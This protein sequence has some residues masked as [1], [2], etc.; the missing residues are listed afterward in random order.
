MI[1]FLERPSPTGSANLSINRSDRAP[2]FTLHDVRLMRLL[3]PHLQR[4]LALHRRFHHINARRSA[5]VS[6]IDRLSYGVILVDARLRPV[7]VNAAANQILSE[8]DG[9]ILDRGALRGS[10]PSETAELRRLVSAAAAVT[11]GVSSSMRDSAMTTGRRSP[12]EPLHVL[13]TPVSTDNQY[14]GA[15]GLA[16]AAVFITDPARIASPDERTLQVLY[17]FTPAEARVAAVLARGLTVPQIAQSLDLTIGTARW[18]VKQLR[19]K[20]GAS[21]HAKLIRQLLG[22]PGSIR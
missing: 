9:L 16:V 17:G 22:G 19:A 15:E 14:A 20:T 18:Y 6:V 5:A 12:R 10:Q 11:T 21:T 1:S 13:V 2:E 7:V 8:R 4:A 3:V